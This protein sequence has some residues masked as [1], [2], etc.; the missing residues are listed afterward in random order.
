MPF[1]G[2]EVFA[3]L[4]I[5]VK[6]DLME[7]IFEYLN[8]DLKEVRLKKQRFMHKVIHCRAIHDNL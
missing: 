6:G 7:V 1:P 5:I 8:K 4:W 3:F 2:G